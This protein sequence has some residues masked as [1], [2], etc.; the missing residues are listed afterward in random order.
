MMLILGYEYKEIRN[1][2]KTSDATIAKL[3]NWISEN[4]NELISVARRIIQLKEKKA[5]NLI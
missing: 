2:T 5:M 3:N 1:R 4:R